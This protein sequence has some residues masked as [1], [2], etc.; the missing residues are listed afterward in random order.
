MLEKT[1]GKRRGGGV[2]EDE[3]VRWDH[4]LDGHEFEPTLEDREGKGNL[5]CCSSWG[6]KELDTT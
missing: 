1:E 4:Q 3:M 2:K 6:H 5:A